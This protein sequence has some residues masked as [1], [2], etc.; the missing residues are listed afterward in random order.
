M[1][2]AASINAKAVATHREKQQ[3]EY[4]VSSA[5]QVVADKLAGGMIEWSYDG[6]GTDGVPSIKSDTLSDLMTRI[7]IGTSNNYKEIWTA[8]RENSK[9]YD[10]TASKGGG[11]AITI[12]SGRA[13]IVDVYAF[14]H[15]DRDMNITVDLSTDSDQRTYRTAAYCLTVTAQCVPHYDTKGKLLSCSWESATIAKTSSSAGGSS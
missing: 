9:T 1:L 14:V 6:I 8:T 13:A 2:T 7:W 10:F 15:I 11:S 3:T 4:T 5:A 12:S